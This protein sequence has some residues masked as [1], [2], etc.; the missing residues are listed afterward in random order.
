MATAADKKKWDSL[1]VSGLKAVE[2]L[3]EYESTLRSKYGKFEYSWLTLSQR[4]KLDKLK[5]RVRTNDSKVV[6]LLVKISPRG[7]KWLTGA[8][9]W[10][11]A[12][13]LKWEDAIRPTNEPLS[14]VV[15]GAYGYPDGYVKEQKTQAA[16]EGHK[17]EIAIPEMDWSQI[18]GD[19]NPSQYGAIIAK[20]DGSSLELIEIQPVREYVSDGEAA[21]VGFPFWSK[22]AY[23]TLEDLDLKNEDVQAAIESVDL[24]EALNGMSPQQRALAI[25]EALLR[26]GVGGEEG[27]G[28]WSSDVLGDRKVKWWTGAVAGSEYI[29]DEDEEFRREILGE[30]D[31]EDEDEEEEDEEPSEHELPTA[32]NIEAGLGDY[33]KHEGHDA[34][35][36]AKRIAKLIAGVRGDPDKADEVLKE[37][38]DLLDAHGIEAIRGDYSVDNYYHDVVALYINMGDSYDATLLY[39]TEN[40][41][42]LVTSFGDWV[43]RNERKY[44]I[45]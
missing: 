3:Y 43:E 33:L 6:D 29:A 39:E 23:Y 20:G 42:F 36:E 10:W 11:I 26:Y 27:P 2:A 30:E 19:M 24:L 41:Q 37:V 21:D 45:Q 25:A 40:E 12:R 18:S 16:R 17:M 34:K 32:E 15:P 14:V 31:E 1:H 5:E 9:T 28:G 35:A 13:E 22:E 38:D 7:D 8:P 4:T 44:S